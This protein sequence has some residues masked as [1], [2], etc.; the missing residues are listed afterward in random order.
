MAS[1]TIKIEG[2]SALGERMRGLAEKV[3]LKIARSAT[4]AGAQVVKKAAVRKAP[5][6]DAPHKLNGV[7]INPGNLKKNIVVKRV[8]PAKTQLT[9]EHLVTVRGKRKDG[10]AARY[11]RLQEFG[12]VDMAAQPFLRPAFDEQK[13][14]ALAAITKKLADA[15][16]KAGK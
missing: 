2:L 3:N 8:N 13:Q 16:T 14:A 5:D 11:G 4:N 12:T 9:S 1:V 6:S 10:Y 15:I 7:V